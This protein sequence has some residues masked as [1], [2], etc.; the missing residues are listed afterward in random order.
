MHFYSLKFTLQ[1]IVFPNGCQT[2]EGTHLPLC[3][4]SMWLD[5]G[6]LKEGYN[7]PVHLTDHEIDDLT[8]MTLR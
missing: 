6:C 3:L 5:I 4:E 1:I 2:Y 7:W 8:H